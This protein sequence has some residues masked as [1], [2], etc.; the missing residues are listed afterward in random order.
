MRHHHEITN[1]CI[2]NGV[3]RRTGSDKKVIIN[4]V[5]QLGLEQGDRREL[6]RNTPY[7]ETRSVCV[8]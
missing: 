5:R 1:E 2:P 8:G 6:T 4:E 3:H 7:F